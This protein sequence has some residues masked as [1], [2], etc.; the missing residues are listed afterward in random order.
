VA[1]GWLY[2]YSRYRKVKRKTRSIE[3]EL[4]ELREI[5]EACGNAQDDHDDDDYQNC[6]SVLEHDDFEE[7]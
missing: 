1:L 7:N 5:Y 3:R 6:S 4:Q 2:L